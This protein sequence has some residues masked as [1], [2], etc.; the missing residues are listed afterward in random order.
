M[1]FTWYQAAWIAFIIVTF[2]FRLIDVGKVLT[3]DEPL[4]RERAGKLVQAL[5]VGDLAG[6]M[7]TAQPGV[8]TTMVAGATHRFN[9]LALDQASL[10]IVNSLL[11]LLTT[12]FLTRL[13]GKWWGLLG[14]ALITLEPYF[15]AHTRL[16]HTDGLMAVAL[17]ASLTAFLAALAPLAHGRSVIKRYL[18]FSG[19]LAGIA[20]LNKL[21]A[22]LILPMIGVL[23]LVTWWQHQS[24]FWEM[25]RRAAWWSAALIITVFALWPVLWLP[26]SPA[27]A[28]LLKWTTVH[29]QGLR[30]GDVTSNWWFYLREIPF[31]LTIPASLLLPF[32]LLAVV[33]P[34]FGKSLGAMRR[35]G[36]TFLLCGIFFATAMSFAAE[37]GDRYVLFTILCLSLF[38]L[39]GL[40]VIASWLASSPAWKKFSLVPALAVLL[41]LIAENI[42]L[43][44]YYLSHY[45][46][47]YPIEERHKVGLGEGLEQAAHWAKAQNPNAKIATFVPRVVEHFYPR[48]AD[49]LEHIADLDPDYI[50]IYRGMFERPPAS[51]ET[52]MVTEYLDSSRK[53]I[54]I[55]TINNLPYVWIYE[56][57]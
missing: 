27:Y 23:L 6:T 25:L 53:P 26:D 13:W 49:S 2:A 39:L 37:K 46:R 17:L 1:K 41:F 24:T 33:V 30:A 44:P 20:L 12:F 31:R 57:E 19:L 15:I 42:R 56:R 18:V 7:T 48:S 43:H 10:A 52:K 34:V 3:I 21:F 47:L 35:T 32:A 22:V 50:F 4:W 29:A 55:V 14:G 51:F 54:H 11:I 9:S 40:R 16:V 38:S 8:I 36:M 5:A 45:N 28:Y